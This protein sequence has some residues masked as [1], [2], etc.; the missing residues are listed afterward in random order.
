L[1]EILNACNHGFLYICNYEISEIQIF[2]MML[3][4]ANGK[5][6]VG[7]TLTAI[8]VA[9][10][11]GRLKPTLLIDSDNVKAST[12]W[13]ARGGHKL[14]FKVV[15]Y[16]QLAKTILETT[17]SHFVFDTKGG[18]SEDDLRMLADGCDLLVIPTTPDP[19]ATDGLLYTLRQLSGKNDKPPVT[20]YR[21][22]INRVEH[23]RPREAAE[24]R[25]ALVSSRT[26]VFDVEIP[27]LAAFSKA[28]GQGLPVSEVNDE[29]AAR[30][31][32]AFEAL[33]KEIINGRKG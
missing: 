8:H 17:Y 33:G 4:I 30:A 28:S 21:V 7:K 23:N 11:L 1:T 26:P 27:E 18:I 10:F 13:S 20:N 16:E 2:K 29:R 14:P 32:A 15:W 31:W 25:A 6:G 19:T 3:G 12:N 5:G 22:L 24:L 9:T